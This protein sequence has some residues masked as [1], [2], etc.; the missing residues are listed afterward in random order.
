LWLGEV[1]WSFMSLGLHA[2][3]AAPQEGWLIR[4]TVLGLTPKRLA[5][6]RTLAFVQGGT[7][8]LFKVEGYSGPPGVC[9]RPWPF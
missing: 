4:C 9:L 2:A 1:A 7:D 8:T 3:A 6:L 5:I